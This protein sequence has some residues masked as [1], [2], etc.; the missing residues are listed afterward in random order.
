M[1]SGRHM[2]ASHIGPLG[3][4]WVIEHDGSHIHLTVEWLD[5]MYR[6]QVKPRQ[7]TVDG[8]STPA[9]GEQA[10]NRLY[11]MVSRGLGSPDEIMELFDDFYGTVVGNRQARADLGLKAVT[12]DGDEDLRAVQNGAPVRPWNAAN[13]TSEL[14]AWIRETRENR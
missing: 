9:E 10:W 2:G 4:G 11:Y 3:D 5:A 8:Q 13:A 14:D 6:H 7:T 12:R 1:E